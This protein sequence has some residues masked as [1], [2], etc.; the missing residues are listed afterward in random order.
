[1]KETLKIMDLHVEVEGKEIIRGLDLVIKEGEVHAIMGPNGSGKSSLSHTIMG[2]PNYRVTSGDI[3]FKG[4]SIL[5]LS[6]DERARMGIFLS[7]Q[8]P[9]AISGVS[10]YSLLR[11]MWNKDSPLVERVDNLAKS[12]LLKEEILYRSINDGLSGGEKK[13]SEIIQMAVK[14]PEF[15][16]L[17]EIDSGLDIDSL[18]AVSEFIKSEKDRGK[19]FLLITHYRRILDH[20]EPDLVHVMVDGKIVKTGGKELVKEL[21]KEGY[22][23]FGGNNEKVSFAGRHL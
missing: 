12:L 18:M 5:G 3:F 14:D 10:L 2:H 22:R 19:T 13:K 11:R 21:E 4:E 9:V 6:T 16:I 17:D 7:F 20:V 8:Y 23:V 1:M 15:I